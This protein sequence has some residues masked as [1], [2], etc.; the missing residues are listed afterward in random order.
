MGLSAT[1][2]KR[3]HGQQIEVTMSNI[4]PEDEEWYRSNNIKVGF[5]E[6]TLEQL[7]IYAEYGE[8]DEES[9]EIIYLVPSGEECIVSMS[10]IRTKIEGIINANK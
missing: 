5:E 9:D 10:K 2:Y 1:I 8:T 3:P 4:T 7:V 6:I